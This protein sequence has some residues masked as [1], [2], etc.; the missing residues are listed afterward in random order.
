MAAP[1]D[2]AGQLATILLAHEKARARA[3]KEKNS[4]A[5]EVLLAPDFIEI[6]GLGLFSEKEILVS[7]L[8]RSACTSSSSLTPG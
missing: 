1:T 6:N 8:L 7:L 2:D 4:R 5:L 3:W